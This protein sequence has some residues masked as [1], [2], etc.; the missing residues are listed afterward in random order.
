[1]QSLGIKKEWNA[2]LTELNESFEKD[3]VLRI[4]SFGNSKNTLLVKNLDEIKKQVGVKFFLIFNLSHGIF[5]KI[6][7]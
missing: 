5:R 6:K 7:T 3:F 4:F 1:L 2:D